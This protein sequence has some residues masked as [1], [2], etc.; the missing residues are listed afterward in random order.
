MNNRGE[1]LSNE[2]NILNIFTWTGVIGVILYSSIFFIASGLAI[3]QS[4]NIYC[5][6]LGVF[7]SFKWAYGWVEDFSRFD[8]NWITTWLLIGMCFSKSIRAK[9]NDEF[10]AWGIDIGKIKLKFT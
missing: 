2:V 1:R 4:N 5:K 6:V 9:S 10:K 7:I 8:I 3:N